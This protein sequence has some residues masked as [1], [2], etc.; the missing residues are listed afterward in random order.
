MRIIAGRR[1]YPTK[2]A[3]EYIGVTESTMRGWRQEEYG[4]KGFRVGRKL[5]YYLEV[6]LDFFIEEQI[7]EKS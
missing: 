6:D 3:A 4:P 5:V 2:A 7:K 1:A